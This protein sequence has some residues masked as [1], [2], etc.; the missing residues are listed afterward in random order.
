MQRVAAESSSPDA[1][2]AEAAQGESEEETE[3]ESEAEE[4]SDRGATRRRISDD[5]EATP[6]LS[7]EEMAKAVRLPLHAHK[8][9][10]AISPFVI[11]PHP[12]PSLCL[13]DRSQCSQ[14]CPLDALSPHHLALLLL[15]SS[16]PGYPLYGSRARNCTL[17]PISSRIASP[18]PLINL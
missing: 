2:M 6:P 16:L 14:L 11:L 13:S 8:F 10:L 4:E 15:F 17:P 9:A 3:S 7:S 12:S 5:V 18:P 1:T